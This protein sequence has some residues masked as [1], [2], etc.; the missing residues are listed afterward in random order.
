MEAS[1]CSP[2]KTPQESGADSD[3]FF[4]LCVPAHGAPRTQ[5]LKLHC[6]WEV[7]EPVDPM[8]A[9]RKPA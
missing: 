4:A 3:K 2:N 7:S 9:W 6:R 8:L 5:G 1:S